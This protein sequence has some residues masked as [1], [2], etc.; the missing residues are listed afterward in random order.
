L[1]Y[2]TFSQNQ[3]QFFPSPGGKYAA[4]K[5][6]DPKNVFCLLRQG[7]QQEPRAAASRPAQYFFVTFLPKPGIPFIMKT[8]QKHGSGDAGR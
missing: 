3:S 5:N 2:D 8:E 4:K 6:R 1:F 7:T